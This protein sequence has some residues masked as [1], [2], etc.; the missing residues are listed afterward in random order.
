MIANRKEYFKKYNKMYK[1]QKKNKDKAKLVYRK[2]LDI[3]AKERG[4]TRQE[5]RRE[6]NYKIKYGIT[7][8]DYD[9]LYAKQEGRCAICEKLSSK[10]SVDHCHKSNKIR[11]LLCL[12][13]NLALGYLDDDPRN[14]IK[15]VNYL[16]TRD[17]LQE[18]VI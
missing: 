14:F 10:L 8:S 2:W 3:K 4:M 18:K 16:K 12:R 11:G 5:Y 6:R 15:A 1:N 13:C 17:I 7:I 9:L